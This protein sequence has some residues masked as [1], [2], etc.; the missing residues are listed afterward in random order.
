MQ[1]KF[2]V[3]FSPPVGDVESRWRT[4]VR[5]TTQLRPGVPKKA[6]E[7]GPSYGDPQASRPASTRSG[8]SL[9]LALTARQPLPT[10]AFACA[11]T[12]EPEE[13][14]NVSPI[15]TLDGVAKAVF[16]VYALNRRKRVVDS[17]RPTL[18]FKGGED[19]FLDGRRPPK[20]L[21]QHA[22]NAHFPQGGF[23]VGTTVDAW[24]RG[25]AVGRIEV[26]PHVR[27]SRPRLST[28]G[29]CGRLPH[30]WHCA[31]PVSLV[32]AGILLKFGPRGCRQ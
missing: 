13:P 5:A 31:P 16:G 28:I 1:A 21:H 4:K 18:F 6:D 7:L 30:G 3:V 24:R 22:L 25:I 2:R 26:P 20:R 27:Q 9:F 23:P 17:R 15:E 8:G 29:L 11:V 10:H 12:M 19:R 14:V 32:L